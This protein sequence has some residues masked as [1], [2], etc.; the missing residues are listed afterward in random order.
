MSAS[1]SQDTLGVQSSTAI[2]PAIGTPIP[3]STLSDDTLHLLEQAA[4]SLG[5]SR[6]NE[7]QPA[8]RKRNES[9]ERDRR[10]NYPKESKALYL[11]TN[12]L[13]RRFEIKAL[14]NYPLQPL[15]WKRF[16]DDIFLI[17]THG[18]DSLKEFLNYLNNLHPTIKFISETSTESINFQTLQ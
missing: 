10:G 18:E 11:K 2:T 14:C 16:I 3:K 9:P 1:A 6:D 13:H 7:N 8:K 4:A 15:I 5:Q 12:S 17:W